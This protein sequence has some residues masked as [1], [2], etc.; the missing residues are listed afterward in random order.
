MDESNTAAQTHAGEM[1]G[2]EHAA[3]E[4]FEFGGRKLSMRGTS[5]PPKNPSRPAEGS[6]IR[7]DIATTAGQADSASETSPAPVQADIRIA[8]GR[9]VQHS[10]GGSQGAAPTLTGSGQLTGG[11]VRRA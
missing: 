6:P 8:E 10:P 9:P 4:F 1:R 5:G 2:N 7:H 11:P 3:E